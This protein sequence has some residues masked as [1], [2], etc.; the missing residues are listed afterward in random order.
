M[1]MSSWHW[2]KYLEKDTD[3]VPGLGFWSSK[4]W[5]YKDAVLIL[6][7]IIYYVQEQ[8]L[9]YS[10]ICLFIITICETKVKESYK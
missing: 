2:K 9:K 5:M 8:E 7:E 6:S 4:I 3:P 10:S 1:I